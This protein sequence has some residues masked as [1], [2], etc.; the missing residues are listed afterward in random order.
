MLPNL[1]KPAFPIILAVLFLVFAALACNMPGSSQAT[2][3]NVIDA[4]STN[5]ALTAAVQNTLNPPT[6]FPTMALPTTQSPPTASP[7]AT[8]QPTATSV[9]CNRAAFVLDVDYPDNTNVQPGT[10]F[11]K[12]WRLKNNGSCTWTSGY[13][14]IFDTGDRMNAPETVVVT[15]GTIAPGQT[16]D[17]AVL[18]TAPT[19]PGTYRGNFLLRAPDGK[20]F[21]IG[22]DGTG[23]FWVQVIVPVPTPTVT[24]KPTETTGVTPSVMP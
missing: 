10:A 12:T 13:V 8:I 4:I 9:P 15:N 1:K 20:R 23:N 11:T 22:P 17:A 7:S 14:I 5:V 24:V 18:L 6:Q 19:A 3:T 2:P 21:G 16:V